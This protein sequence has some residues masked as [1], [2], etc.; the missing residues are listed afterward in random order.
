MRMITSQGFNLLRTPYRII[1]TSSI[2]F[3]VTVCLLTGQDESDFLTAFI[4]EGHNHGC[5]TPKHEALA[6][7]G[8]YPYRMGQNL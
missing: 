7:L 8:F 5:P 6:D 3:G 1:P 2:S 4:I